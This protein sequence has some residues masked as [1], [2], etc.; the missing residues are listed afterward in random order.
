MSKWHFSNVGHDESVVV[1]VLAVNGIVLF[2]YFSVYMPMFQ[3]RVN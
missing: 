3:D 2:V 1:A